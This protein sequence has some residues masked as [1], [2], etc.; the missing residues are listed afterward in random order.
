MCLQAIL[1]EKLEEE[2]KHEEARESLNPY[3]DRVSSS[4]IPTKN[5]TFFS[6]SV[7][8][9]E[10]IMDRAN[11]SANTSLNWFELDYKSRPKLEPISSRHNEQSYLGVSRPPVK[12]LITSSGPI[13]PSEEELKVKIEMYQAMLDRF[14]LAKVKLKKMRIQNEGLGASTRVSSTAAIKKLKDELVNQKTKILK[15]SSEISTLKA[16]LQAAE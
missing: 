3:P 8:E 15:A 14:N 2:E 6:K 7:E 16:L 12:K 10:N 11:T 9:T 13:I 5:K 1:E 4:L